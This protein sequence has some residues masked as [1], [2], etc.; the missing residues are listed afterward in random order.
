MHAR[1]CA[2]PLVT[3][4][5]HSAATLSAAAGI[6][7]VEAYHAGIIRT[8]LAGLVADDIDTPFG[9]VEAVVQLI[10]DLR[11][12]IDGPPNDGLD[13]DQGIFEGDAI[14]LVPTDAN[15]LVYG[16]TVAQTLGVAYL[17]NVDNG[18]FFPRGVSGF[19]GPQVCAMNAV[20]DMRTL[21]PG[22]LT[23]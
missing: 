3:L 16:R 5:L 1:A 22:N 11:D 20:R 9:P 2:G 12:R 4:L 14:N 15:G 6:L 23:G 17:G 21:P 10:S 18:G 13:V 7:A 19:F 8:L